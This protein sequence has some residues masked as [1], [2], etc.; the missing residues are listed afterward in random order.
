MFDLDIKVTLRSKVILQFWLMCPNHRTKLHQTI[1]SACLQHDL[2][3]RD[4]EVEV[5]PRSMGVEVL[6]LLSSITQSN[7]TKL[8][9][10]YEQSMTNYSVNLRSWSLPQ[11]SIHF[12]R[13][14][15]K[16]MC[17]RILGFLANQAMKGHET[18]NAFKWP[19]VLFFSLQNLQLVMVFL[20]KS[21][22]R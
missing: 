17:S 16:P 19:T 18:G 4:L 15:E 7:S 14:K 21:D 2:S 1:C 6:Y 10:V 5:T 3:R 8:G 9:E 20:Q 11:R 12:F 13:A 22:T